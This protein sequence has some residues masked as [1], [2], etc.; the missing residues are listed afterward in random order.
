MLAVA[1]PPA[2]ANDSRAPM[3][4]GRRTP[5]NSATPTPECGGWWGGRVWPG[6]ASA[7]PEPLGGAG[8]QGLVPRSERPY[9]CSTDLTTM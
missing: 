3:V 5:F 8:C 9:F 1:G 4:R 7:E 6:A 2:R